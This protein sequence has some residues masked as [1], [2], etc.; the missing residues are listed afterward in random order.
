MVSSDA[1]ARCVCPCIFRSTNEIYYICISL[2]SFYIFFICIY[3]KAMIEFYFC[4]IQKNHGLGK[5]STL[6]IPSITKTSYNYW[7]KSGC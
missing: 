5:V 1:A 4:D 2:N 7:L 3:T 6:S